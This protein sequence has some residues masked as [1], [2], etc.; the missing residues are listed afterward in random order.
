[1]KIAPIKITVSVNGETTFSLLE[2]GKIII[3]KKNVEI[4]VKE[5]KRRYPEL[6]EKII[7]YERNISSIR[8]VE[9][10]D[11]SSL[12]PTHRELLSKTFLDVK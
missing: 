5:V 9:E 4:I 11:V 1:M 12:N 7:F 8:D 2:N 3:P 10:I 6:S